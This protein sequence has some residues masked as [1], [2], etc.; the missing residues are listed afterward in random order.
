[1]LCPECGDEMRIR[2]DRFPDCESCG[3]EQYDE[4]TLALIAEVKREQALAKQVL[5]YVPNYDEARWRGFAK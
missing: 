4:N 1:M 5:G 3:F 2:E